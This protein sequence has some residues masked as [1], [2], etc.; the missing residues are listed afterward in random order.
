ME[1]LNYH[2]EIADGD[3]PDSCV[4]C[5]AGGTLLTR[6]V[7]T[8]PIPVLGGPFQY[9]EVALPMCPE[10]VKAPLVSLSY[11]GVRQFTEDGVIVTNVSAAFVQALTR[12]RESQRHKRRQRGEPEPPPLRLAP[13]GP[14]Q[15]SPERQRAY[16]LFIVACIVAAILA[17]VIIGGLVVLLGPKGKDRHPGAAPQV[18]APQNIP[19]APRPLA[20]DGGIP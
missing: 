1:T 8:T 3:F 7:L 19:Q 20:P 9:G 4:R 5:G 2:R 11:P 16:R 17:G 14:P 12:H 6:I 15:L 10:H 18:P 13:A